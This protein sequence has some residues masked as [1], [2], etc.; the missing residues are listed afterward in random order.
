MPRS[1][2]ARIVV[3]VAVIALIGFAVSRFRGDDVRHSYPR[4]TDVYAGLGAWIDGFDTSLLVPD[5]MEKLALDGVRTLFLQAS[6]TDDLTGEFLKEALK[7]DIRVVGWY[8]PKFADV[9]D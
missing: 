7:R 3:L 5:D 6:K 2:V 9:D 8:V 1:A 4:D